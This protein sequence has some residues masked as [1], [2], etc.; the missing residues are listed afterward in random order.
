MSNYKAMR[1]AEQIPQGSS[2]SI[3]T[4]QK[5]KEYTSEEAKKELEQKYGGPLSGNSINFDME[6]YV[7]LLKAYNSLD[8]L[9]GNYSDMEKIDLIKFTMLMSFTILSNQ[10]EFLVFFY[11]MFYQSWIE[12]IINSQ[13]VEFSL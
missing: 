6:D 9:K 12:V 13:K 3:E 8:F 5:E 11:I 2:D 4:F 10:P 1:S 7:N